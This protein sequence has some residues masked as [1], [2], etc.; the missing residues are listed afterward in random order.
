MSLGSTG[1]FASTVTS[2]RINCTSK[3]MFSVQYH[4]RLRCSIP[5]VREQQIATQGHLRY[6]S[7]VN[8]KR[9]LGF[10]TS[11]YRWQ[12]KVDVFTLIACE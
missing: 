12:C 2:E 10:A 8:T 7:V 5:K 11:K 3:T 4:I 9:N 6:I 1:D